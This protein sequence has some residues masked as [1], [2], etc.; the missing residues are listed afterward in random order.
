MFAPATT[1]RAS[2]QTPGCDRAFAVR[3][4]DELDVDLLA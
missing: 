3:H 1:E 4:T 2:D